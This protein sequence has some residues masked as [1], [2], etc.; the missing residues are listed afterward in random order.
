MKKVYLIHGWEGTPDNNWLPWLKKELEAQGFDVFAPLMP[1][2]ENPVKSVWLKAMQDLVKNPDQNTY[3]VGHSMGCQAIQ[4]YLESLE[5]NVNIG[6]AV[7]VAG[8]INDPYWEG[9][10]EEE[11][12]VVHDWFDVSKDY[13]KIKSHCKKFV[14]IFSSDDPFILKPNWNEAKDILGSEVLILEDRG[15][16]DGK[17]LPEAIEVLLKF[18]KKNL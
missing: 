15:H 11:L 14:S 12:K 13:E 5:G 16:F 2:T 6:G 17:E 18:S 3:L 1:G 8:W 9:R 4:R 10:T 7:L